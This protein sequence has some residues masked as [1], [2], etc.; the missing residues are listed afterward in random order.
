MTAA[1]G[2]IVSVPLPRG[3]KRFL[4]LDYTLAGEG[5]TYATVTAG[6]TDAEEVDIPLNAQKRDK[7]TGEIPD[8]AAQTDALN[9]A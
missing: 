4:K 1:V 7:T 2:I 3:M 5:L 9:N 6:I 8:L